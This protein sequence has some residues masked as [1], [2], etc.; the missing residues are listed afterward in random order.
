MPTQPRR[1]FWSTVLNCQPRLWLYFVTGTCESRG[2]GL[3]VFGVTDTKLAL[4]FGYDVTTVLC[5]LGHLGV[6][7]QELEARIIR[8]PTVGKLHGHRMCWKLSRSEQTA[9]VSPKIL[10][11][12]F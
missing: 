12:D 1:I 11:C 2:H 7:G 6:I 4:Q 9:R 5:T 3:E 8:H 10:R